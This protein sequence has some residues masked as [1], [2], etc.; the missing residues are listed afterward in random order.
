MMMT[1]A[2]EPECLALA[3]AHSKS[4]IRDLT[5][6]CNERA[7]EHNRAQTRCIEESYALAE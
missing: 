7:L 3:R 5:G 6:A 1:P 4:Q 2:R